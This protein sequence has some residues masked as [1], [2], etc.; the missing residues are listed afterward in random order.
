M[1]DEDSYSRPDSIHGAPKEA[2][3]MPKAVGI[4]VFLGRKLDTS[5]LILLGS[6]IRSG[7]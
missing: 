6:F 7:H 4:G 5:F 3:Y 1:I 2:E